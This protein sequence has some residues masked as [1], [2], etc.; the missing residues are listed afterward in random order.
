MPPSANSPNSRKLERSK[1]RTAAVRPRDGPPR[2]QKWMVS[3]PRWWGLGG[4]PWI[5]RA[6]SWRGLMPRTV[7]VHIWGGRLSHHSPPPFLPSPS[8]QPHPPSPLRASRH[9]T[10]LNP[11]TTPPAV[12]P[13]LSCGLV[14]S[15]CLI[16]PKAYRFVRFV[17]VVRSRS[18]RVRPVRGGACVHYG[19]QSRELTEINGTSSEF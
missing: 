19:G 15:L 5:G 4:Y 7:L 10:P 3:C 12:V 6:S 9:P 16:L 8:L 14:A 17:S 2:P 1:H 13:W 11:R 18:G